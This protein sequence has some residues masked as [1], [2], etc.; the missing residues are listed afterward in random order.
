[1]AKHYSVRFLKLRIFIF[2]EDALIKGAA[3]ICGGERINHFGEMDK[4]GYYIQP[5]L[6]RI[7]DIKKREICYVLM[8]KSS[9]LCFLW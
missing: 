7:D 3:L 9:F 8:K 5:T 2:L 1:M 6:I 4:E